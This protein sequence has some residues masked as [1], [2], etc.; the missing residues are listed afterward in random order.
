MDVLR[1][2]VSEGQ[3]ACSQVISRTRAAASSCEEAAG[4]H[5]VKA[6]YTGGNNTLY[7][8]NKEQDQGWHKQLTSAEDPYPLVR[9]TD[10]SIIKQK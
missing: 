3:E 2:E 8:L 5:E 7:G 9:G 10:P 4:A 1:E 6:A